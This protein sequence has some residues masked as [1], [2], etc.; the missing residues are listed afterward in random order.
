MW[1]TINAMPENL[2][3]RERETIPFVQWNGWAI[4]PVRTGVEI[5]AIY[6]DSITERSST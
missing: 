1:L 6:P 2:Y 4:M 3:S 5:A